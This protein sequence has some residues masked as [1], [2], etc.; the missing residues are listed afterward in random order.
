M[1]CSGLRMFGGKCRMT[2]SSPSV[3][4]WLGRYTD[5]SDA[6]VAQGIERCPA[7]AEVACSN[8]AGRT[9][10]AK[11]RPLRGHDDLRRILRSVN[12]PQPRMSAAAA[13][14]PIG[15]V[16]MQLA[17]GAEMPRYRADRAGGARLR[18]RRPGWRGGWDLER[19]GGVARSTARP[20][21]F[22]ARFFGG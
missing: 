5:R 19:V 13:D 16:P 11:I 4:P 7:E 1:G 20:P 22:P 10:P 14:G 8:H 18:R 15:F 2:Q 12:E 17:T 6:P 3:A 21:P 9:W